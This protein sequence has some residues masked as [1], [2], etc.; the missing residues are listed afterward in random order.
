M[1]SISDIPTIKYCQILGSMDKSK[2][3]IP[4]ECRIGDTCFMSFA[5]IGDNLDTRHA[6]NLNNLHR[7]SK[8]L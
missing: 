5:T 1:V 8:D 6:K 4:K 2:E 3:K 7:D